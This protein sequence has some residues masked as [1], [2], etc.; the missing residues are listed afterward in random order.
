MPDRPDMFFSG[1]IVEMDLLLFAYDRTG[2]RGVA[3]QLKGLR[4]IGGA[5]RGIN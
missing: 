3:A 2:F 4:L 5:I 1:Q